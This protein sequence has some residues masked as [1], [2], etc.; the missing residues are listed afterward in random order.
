ML[1]GCKNCNWEGHADM[2]PIRCPNCNKFGS[3]FLK[4]KADGTPIQPPIKAI[5][6]F[7]LILAVIASLVFAAIAFSMSTDD[8]NGNGDTDNVCYYDFEFTTTTHIGDYYSSL[9]IYQYEASTGYKFAIATVYVENYAYS[10]V[11]TSPIYWELYVNNVAYSYDLSTFDDSINSASVTV[12]NGGSYTFQVV[13]E[14]PE[15][16]MTASLSYDNYLPAMIHDGSL[17]P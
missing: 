14:I 7:L 17:I 4:A 1:Y 9:G 12:G 6:W 11:Y 10:S 5:G 3:N 2:R 13:Y 8:S 16:A 15:S